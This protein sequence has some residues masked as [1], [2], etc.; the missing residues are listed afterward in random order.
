MTI[1][2][3]LISHLRANGPSQV[4]AL[5]N[6]KEKD[7]E[8]APL[9]DRSDRVELSEEGQAMASEAAQEGLSPERLDEIVQ[10][11]EDGTY[12]TEAMAE[13]VARR[14]LSSGDL[15]I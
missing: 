10:R 3:V 5:R 4:R 7:S 14:L 11:M 12:D 9:Q 8:R 2:D 13:E 1:R 6:P 15:E